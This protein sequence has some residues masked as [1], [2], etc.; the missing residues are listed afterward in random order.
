MNGWD[1]WMDG[2]LHEKRPQRPLLYVMVEIHH[3]KTFSYIIYYRISKTFD[4]FMMISIIKLKCFQI[5][6]MLEFLCV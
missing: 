2:K 3:K 6:L 5:N 1:G 4:K